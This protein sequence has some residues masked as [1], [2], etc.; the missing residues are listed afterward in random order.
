MKVGKRQQQ[1]QTGESKTGSNPREICVIYGVES[2]RL[3]KERKVLSKRIVHVF[4]ERLT[5]YPVLKPS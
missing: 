5:C 4:E 3:T 1:G 2:Y